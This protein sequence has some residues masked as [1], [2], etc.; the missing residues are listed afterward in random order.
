MRERAQVL[1]RLTGVRDTVPIR[2]RAH[3]DVSLIDGQPIAVLRS[4]FLG[5]G[6]AASSSSKR[7]GD[8]STNPEPPGPTAT[9][10]SPRPAKALRAAAPTTTMGPR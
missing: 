7:A 10:T 4:A 1:K 9:P 3:H 6:L 8:L 2:V 5:E